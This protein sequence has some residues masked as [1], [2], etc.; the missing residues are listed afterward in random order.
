LGT[1]PE[2]AA[3]TITRA[4]AAQHLDVV[5]LAVRARQ[6]ANP[7]VALVREF[8]AL[9]AAQDPAAAAY[10]HRGSTS[11]DIFDTAAMLVARRALALIRAD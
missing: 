10:V 1:V 5:A 7:V 6:S 9:V 3:R 4:A 2:G 11:Q 8:T